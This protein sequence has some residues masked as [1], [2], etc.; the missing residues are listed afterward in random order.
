MVNCLLNLPRAQSNQ[1]QQNVIAVTRIYVLFKL[2]AHTTVI[3][4]LNRF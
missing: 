4:T 3:T 1:Y 2:L